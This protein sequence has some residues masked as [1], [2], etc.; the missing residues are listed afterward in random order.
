MQQLCV[1]WLS[2]ISKF[3]MPKSWTW[4]VSVVSDT[5]SR[6]QSQ[7]TGKKLTKNIVRELVYWTWPNKALKTIK[8]VQLLEGGTMWIPLLRDS[9]GAN[10][11][12]RTDIAKNLTES[13]CVCTLTFC[14]KH[15]GE[16]WIITNTAEEGRGGYFQ[17]RQS[18]QW[19]NEE[20]A[21]TCCSVCTTEEAER[22]IICNSE[23]QRHQRSICS[24]FSSL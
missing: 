11:I 9:D 13:S 24:D 22:A 14:A 10:N 23:Q 19:T 21:Q 2:M 12:A 15:I 6:L 18:L 5:R 7:V 8:S 20:R 4:P 3:R 17:A 1:I 16:W